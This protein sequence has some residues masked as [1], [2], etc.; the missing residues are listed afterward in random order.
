MADPDE[1][2]AAQQVGPDKPPRDGEAEKDTSP[3][4]TTGGPGGDEKSEP[5]R[6]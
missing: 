4:G 6:G 3:R 5:H 2:K 1:E